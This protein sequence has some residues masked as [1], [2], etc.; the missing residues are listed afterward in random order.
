MRTKRVVAVLAVFTAGVAVGVV[1]TAAKSFDTSL[2]LGKEPKAAALALLDQAKEQAGKGSWENLAVA[3]T[4]YLMGEEGRAGSIFDQVTSGKMKEEDWMRLGRIYAEGDDW[5]QARQAFEKAL[6]A[7]PKDA[8]N[9]AEVGAWYNLHG[10]RAKAE[11]LFVRAFER[12]PDEVWVT[13]DVASSYVGVR[14]HP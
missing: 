3:R 6:D 14:P 5:D 13:V 9:L 11:E 2:F 10:D 4:Y 7:D 1:A 8:E 12:K